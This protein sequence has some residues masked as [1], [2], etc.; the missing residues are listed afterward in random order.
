MNY[1]LAEK[2]GLPRLHLPLMQP[3]KIMLSRGQKIVKGMY[4]CRGTCA[5]YNTDIWGDCAPADYYVP[6]TSRL[7]G[8]LWL[9]L[10]TFKHY[11]YTH[12]QEFALEYSPVLKENALF[13]LD[14]MFK[15]ANGFYAIGPPAS[16]ENAYMTQDGQAATV[17]LNPS[18]DIQLLREFFTSYSQLLK[19]LNRYDFEAEINEYLEKLP[20]IQT[21]E[22]GQI[23]E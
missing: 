7:M 10:R 17:C 1:W 12:N 15:N 13:F 16:P 6:S 8:L 3:Q 14:Y 19:E 9:P 18:V 4:G 21:G 20:L 5:H 11:Q 2:V 23:M 22:Y